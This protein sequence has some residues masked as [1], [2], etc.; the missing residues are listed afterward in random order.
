M[1]DMSR[2]GCFHF[3]A[4]VASY[5]GGADKKSDHTVIDLGSVDCQHAESRAGTYELGQP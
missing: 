1:S 2:V 3:G 5:L 4:E